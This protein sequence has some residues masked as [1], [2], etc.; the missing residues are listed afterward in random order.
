MIEFLKKIFCE[1]LL[2][3]ILIVFIILKIEDLF[4]PLFWDEAWVYGPSIIEMSKGF[5]SLIPSI[6]NI[7]L[8]RGHPLLFHFLGGIW[9]KLF[10]QSLFS[11]HSFPLLISLVTLISL[12]VITFKITQKKIT[13]LFSVIILIV[14][15]I[16]FIQ[17]SIILPEIMLALFAIWALYFYFIENKIGYLISSSLLLYTKESGVVLIILLLLL[18]LFKLIFIYANKRD[19]IK[20]IGIILSPLLIISI[21]FIVQKLKFGWYFFPE[22]I[23]YVEIDY[24][25]VKAKIKSVFNFIFEEQGRITFSYLL[26]IS[27]IIGFNNSKI[28]K[29]VLVLLFLY[30]I[31]KLMFNRW[32]IAKYINEIISILLISSIPFIFL[33]EIKENNKKIYLSITIILFIISHSIFSSINF[34]SFRYLII[35]FPLLILIIVILIDNSKTNYNYLLLISTSIIVSLFNINSINNDKHIGDTNFNYRNAVKV[36]QKTI[37]YLKK[38]KLE[39]TKIY[40]SFIIQNALSSSYSGYI[41]DNKFFTRIHNNSNEKDIEYYIFT[42]IEEDENKETILAKNQV[43][44][45]LKIESGIVFSEIYKSKTPTLSP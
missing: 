2:G 45:I 1:I 3:I 13:G 44:L 30:S 11:L 35:I 32:D 37:S 26:P 40:T 31:V 20:F 5:P 14:Q 18:E 38:M 29:R 22:H 21:H 4:L 8:Q 17:S 15:P 7:E 9:V 19:S 43:E 33:H 10:G 34:I 39:N 25:T 23:N 16:F 12:Y 36:Q 28:W 27:I 24:E 42:N 41:T 6:E